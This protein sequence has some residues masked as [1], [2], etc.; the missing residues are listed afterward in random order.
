MQLYMKFIGIDGGDRVIMKYIDKMILLNIL[1][2]CTKNSHFYYLNN[3]I[4]I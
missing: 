1:S 4:N 3:G 2:F